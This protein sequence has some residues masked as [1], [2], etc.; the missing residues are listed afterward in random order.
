[1]GGLAT[2]SRFRTARPSKIKS[3]KLR[4]KVDTTKIIDVAQEAPSIDMLIELSELQLA[5]VGGGI[6]NTTPI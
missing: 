2:R 4:K 3:T 5:L 6:G 1:V